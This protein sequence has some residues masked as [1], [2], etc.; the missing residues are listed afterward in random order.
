MT[1]VTEK[2]YLQWGINDTGDR[3]EILTMGYL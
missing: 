1:W 2:R 3:E